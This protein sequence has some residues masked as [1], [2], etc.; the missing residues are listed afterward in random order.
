MTGTAQDRSPRCY[1]CRGRVLGEL[2]TRP[3]RVRCGRCGAVNVDRE[4]LAVLR[5]GAEGAR[6]EA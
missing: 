6:M 1:K 5:A 4:T 2:L 3:W